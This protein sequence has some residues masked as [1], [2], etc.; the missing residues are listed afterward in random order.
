MGSNSVVK[1]VAK[2]L[3]YYF[4]VKCLEDGFDL[5]THKASDLGHPSQRARPAL[6]YE[7]L[8]DRALKHYFSQPEVRVELT[9]LG[10]ADSEREHNPR[11]RQIKKSLKNTMKKYQFGKGQVPE[12]YYTYTFG[13]PRHQPVPSDFRALLAQTR[14]TKAVKAG[15]V[16]GGQVPPPDVP[17][18]EADRLVHNASRILANTGSANSHHRGRQRGKTCL[19][20]YPLGPLERP[21]SD[22]KPRPVT[23]KF[24][25]DTN[26]HQV[27]SEKV[28]A[29]DDSRVDK[30]PRRSYLRRPQSSPR[31]TSQKTVKS[32]QEPSPSPSGDSSSLS[33]N[34]TP[35]HR[36]RALRQQQGTLVTEDA[37]DE[38]VEE[39]TEE[40][41][42]EYRLTVK[43]GNCIGASTT[44]AVQLTLYGVKGRSPALHLANSQNNKVKFQRGKEDLFVLNTPHVGQMNKIRIGHDRPELSYAWF[45]ESVT[46]QDVREGQVYLLP[47]H[48]WLSGQDEDRHTHC[49]FLVNQ[50]KDTEKSQAQAS[51]S[52]S[53]KT[54]PRSATLRKET[55]S[56]PRQQPAPGKAWSGSGRA[57]SAKTGPQSRRKEPEVQGRTKGSKPSLGHQDERGK[58]RRPKPV[59][60]DYVA[61]Y[62]AE[63]E[64]IEA[65]EI[66]KGEEERAKHRQLL[67]G[68]S[69]HDASR[70]GDLKRVKELLQTFPEMTEVTDENGWTALHIAADSGKVDIIKRL[71]SSGCENLDV[72]T[73]TGY[74]PTH[75]AARNGH[76]AAVKVLNAMGASMD[77]R[78]VDQQ[79]PLHLAASSGH[80]E[81]VKC[82]VANGADLTAED[83]FSRTPLD[84]AGEHGQ[85]S[86]THFL[87]QCHRDLD[88]PS[89]TFAQMHRSQSTGGSQKAGKAEPK[90]SEKKARQSEENQEPRPMTSSQRKRAKEE[91]ELQEK[92]ELYE[93]Q[94][95][96]MEQEGV[97]FLDQIR[98]EMED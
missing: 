52:T 98:Q 67:A 65:S 64:A 50:P 53:K 84:L 60:H 16:E 47:C 4:D 42:A 35:V 28:K 9:K 90:Q 86:V 49:T 94:H 3:K 17:P 22:G 11:E 5:S 55:N 56:N 40:P 72:E 75:L 6:Q 26:G 18:E 2:Q 93:E 21:R 54:K 73:P 43:T 58:D 83:S 29:H 19:Q 66:Q 70:K 68:L 80:L 59:E 69:I 61:E 14:K 97:S 77:C 79:T 37:E 7:G 25:W 71:T 13:G 62:N 51:S 41:V 39:V 20:R 81:C 34:Q 24:S 89:S 44:A 30:V 57:Q 23:A 46:L 45:L 36:V 15:W 12:W 8:H 33:P 91:K 95:R 87:Q 78:T 85:G 38:G 48:R 31:P 76:N 82:L 10:P 88:N 32:R 74:T 27:P 63:L 1:T 96:H 92:R